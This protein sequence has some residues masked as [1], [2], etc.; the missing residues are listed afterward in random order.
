LSARSCFRA[1]SLERIRLSQASILTLIPDLWRCSMRSRAFAGGAGLVVFFFS[2]CCFPVGGLAIGGIEDHFEPRGRPH[3]AHDRLI[4]H[5]GTGRIAVSGVFRVFFSA[6]HH[7]PALVAQSGLFAADPTC[8]LMVPL[9][10]RGASRLILGC[11]RSGATPGTVQ[12]R[13]QEKPAA[14]FRGADHWRSW[15]SSR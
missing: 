15:C 1:R 2:C 8:F 6:G 11:F 10:I 3:R 9:V 14:T 12:P 4:P 7:F 5:H 13:V